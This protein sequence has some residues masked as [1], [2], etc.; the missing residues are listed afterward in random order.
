[1]NDVLH[2]PRPAAAG[3]A[4]VIDLDRV[5]RTGDARAALARHVDAAGTDV[6]IILGV[7][8]SQGVRNRYLGAA[9][10]LNVQLQLAKAGSSSEE[11][12][13]TRVLNM[14]RKGAYTRVVHA[15]D[16]R[17]QRGRSRMLLIDL[18]NIA[19]TGRGD[20]ARLLRTAGDVTSAVA[21]TARPQP[22]ALTKA[23]STYGVALTVCARGRNAADEA[24]LALA[25]EGVREGD[26]GSFVIASSD[27]IFTRLERDFDVV[28][29]EG[30]AVSK[31]LAQE[32]RSVST[33]IR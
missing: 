12:A 6:R 18:E 1:M 30:N 26:V 21:V 4:L 23:L 5:A 9:K 28:V 20:L 25:R 17:P 31:R 7:A 15:P 33:F 22:R 24:L 32:A 3:T 14:R 2:G 10:A 29:P 11:L 19:L 8:G 13:T 27:G 16:P